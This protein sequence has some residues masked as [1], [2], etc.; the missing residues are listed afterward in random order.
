MQ[1]FRQRGANFKTVLEVRLILFHRLVY[2]DLISNIAVKCTFGIS[3]KYLRICKSEIVATVRG[4]LH[5]RF[6]IRIPKR[7]DVRFS[8]KGVQQ[9]NF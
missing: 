6:P 3:P 9:V 8:A 1:K 7:F 5:V 4:C 2:M